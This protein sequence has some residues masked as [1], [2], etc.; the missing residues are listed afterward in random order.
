MVKIT[1]KNITLPGQATSYKI[2]QMKI[3]ALR[4]RAE[5]ALGADFD[6][7]EFHDVVLINGALP[8]TV[9]EA[10]VDRWIAENT[11]S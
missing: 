4:Q 6:V 3:M 7:R 11:Q 1:G 2:G 9:L 5:A 8:L 10:Q